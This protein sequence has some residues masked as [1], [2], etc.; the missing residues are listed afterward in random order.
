GLTKNGTTM[1][2]ISYMSPE[3]TRGEDVDHRTDIWSFGVVLYEM[4]TGQLPFR[5]E[6]EQAVIYSIMNEEPK[7]F[8]EIRTDAS[9]ELEEITKKA[10][11]KD[12]GDRYQAISEMKIDL[13][14]LQKEKEPFFETRS[15]RHKE[16]K[17][18]TK[19]LKII[20]MSVGFLFLLIVGYLLLKPYYSD[21]FLVREPIPIAVISFENHTGDKSYDHLQ[22]VI[23]N[24]LITKL[25][26]SQ[27]LQV[28]TWER[29]YD[30]LKQLGKGDVEIIDKDLAFEACR[31]DG[32]DAVVLGSYTKLGNMFATE[33]KLLDV[34]TKRFIKSTSS[35]GEGEDS[36]LRQID[37][38]G[39]EISKGIGLSERKIE[40][41]QQPLREVTTTSMEAYNYFIRGREEHRKRY[42]KEARW[43]LEKSVELDSTFAIAHLWFAWSNGYLGN[44]ELQ[45]EHYDK[46]KRYSGKATEKER[47]YIEAFYASLIEGNPEKKFN[48][49]KQ[50]IKKYPKEK[51]VYD[52][53]GSWH[54]SRNQYDQAIKYYNKAL[55]LDPNFGIV[56]NKLAY[57]YADMGNFEKAIEYLKRYANVSPGD[58]SPFDSMGDI[59]YEMG[60]IDEAITKY[61]EALTVKPDFQSSPKL[62]YLLALKEEYHETIKW[63]D[64]YFDTAPSDFIRTK[65]CAYRGFYQYW[66]GNKDSCLINYQRA[67]ELAELI[68]NETWF[69]GM[70]WLSA[71]VYYDIG[72]YELGKRN[73]KKWIDFRIK[74]VP[75]DS[76]VRRLDWNIYQGF[77]HLKEGDIDS[78]KSKLLIAK[79]FYELLE[80]EQTMR[81][82]SYDIL[83]GEVLLAE[84]RVDEAIFIC[85]NPTSNT[86]PDFEFSLLITYNFPFLK[87]VL[88]RSFLKK[89][90]L[91]SAIAEYERLIDVDLNVKLRRLIN[92][93]YHYRLAK[94]YE[95]KGA[96][97][98]AIKEYEKFLDIWKDADEDLPE[99][100]DA[101]ERLAKLKQRK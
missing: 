88:A 48:L 99:K 87:D 38:L 42:Y 33:V 56:L 64:H 95:K 94:L 77:I 66:L 3:Q 61:K 45:R 84:G 71:W 16:E 46:A 11:V 59:Y 62:A 44:F 25:E 70:D 53:L 24:L 57:C 50:I 9:D 23:P 14:R 82:L 19:R 30:L 29:M 39:K 13:A 21:R 58:A 26:Q 8:R 74:S 98:K 34:E 96:V 80:N 67:K 40:Q 54:R 47:L 92:P 52:D 4:I 32:V 37:E 41:D 2:T 85:K 49:L 35:R 22:K 1:G 97:N 20:S 27:Y 15:S 69:N 7:P 18:K 73:F 60:K 79:S 65:A 100:I 12:L 93:K 28:T 31:L 6:Y 17:S 78:A 101:K 63:F 91:D 89:G 51:G 76:T 90:E 83:H 43:F 10:M 5:G 55:E 72:D 81:G 75:K 68:E 86:I 36:I